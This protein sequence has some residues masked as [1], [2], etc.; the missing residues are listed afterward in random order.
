MKTMI[1]V[2]LLSILLTAGAA[3][4]EPAKVKVASISLNAVIQSG[5]FYD[6]IRLLALDKDTLAAIQKVNAEIKA[7]QQD[8]VDAQDQGKLNDLQ[9]KLQFLHQKI[10]LLVQRSAGGRQTRDFQAL[11]REFVIATYKDKYQL[12]Y[13][14]DAGGADSI[15]WKGGVEITDITDEVT[16]KL[17]E[18]LSE[19][20]IGS[21]G[22]SPYL[23]P[24]TAIPQTRPAPTLPPAAKPSPP[25]TPPPTVKH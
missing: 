24:A 2:A 15:L 21:I 19:I 9:N 20:S 12:I 25:P 5:N 1:S 8:I 23:V 18:R 14:Q 11:L 22:G 7:V 10:S 16:D 4:Q 6:R 3:G 17:R 13:Q